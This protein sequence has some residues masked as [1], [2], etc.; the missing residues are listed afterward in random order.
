[1]NGSRLLAVL[2]KEFIQMRRD[3][4]TFAIMVGVPLM[5]LILFGYAI[6]TDPKNLP[7]A[8]VVPEPSVYSRS[9]LQALEHSGYY[10]LTRQVASS[11]EA[12]H[13]LG[14]GEVQFVVTFPQDLTRK[15]ERGEQPSILV[16]VDASDPTAVGN[17]IAALSDLARRA[18]EHDVPA[19]RGGQPAGVPPIDLRVHRRYNP[20]NLSSRNIV[21]GL[22]GVVLT[23]TMVVMTA[24]AVTRERERGTME[25]LLAMGIRP[26]E[27]MVGK[28]TPYVVVGYIQVILILIFAKILF[29]VPMVGD[30]SLL[31]LALIVF[32][33]VNLAVGFTFSTIAQNQLQAV[34]MSVFFLLPSIL[35]T[36]FMF[37]FRGMP[38]WA[39][40]IGEALP[41]THFMRIIRG[42]LLKG[43]GWTEIWPDFWP[44]L[45][46]LTVVTFVALR[47][48]RM[49]LD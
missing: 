13:L 41:N 37:P 44:L 29:A 5:Q 9:I 14:E 49:T 46:I 16:E 38:R 22:I 48:Y 39:Q 19:L 32:I 1:M 10:R 40:I 3:R 47:R 26:I 35:L 23:L 30:L 24:I 34:Q 15:V 33:M 20:E 36:G 12:D 27:V 31:S 11:V 7:M 45:L 43:D 4:V 28:I 17:G 8:V 42:V 25:T 18:L 6:N 21:P 2:I